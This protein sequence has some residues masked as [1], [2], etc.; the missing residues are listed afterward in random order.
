MTGDG[1]AACARAGAGPA[2]RG[3]AHTLP[4]AG[5][6]LRAETTEALKDSPQ[7]V[8]TGSE[9]DA[10]TSWKAWGTLTACPPGCRQLTGALL[11]STISAH[12]ARAPQGGRSEK[13]TRILCQSM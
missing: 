9:P 5:S 6:S 3:A 12:L 2:W 1:Q 8:G 10:E 4:Q 7:P 13:T 11:T